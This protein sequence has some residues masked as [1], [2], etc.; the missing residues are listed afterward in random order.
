MGVNV[1]DSL[2]GITLG[3]L[4]ASKAVTLDRN[5]R[6]KGSLVHDT[7]DHFK[8]ET[9]ADG[10]TVRINSRSYTQAS[11]GSIGYQSKPSQTVTTT[12]EVIGAELSP[13]L[14]SGIGAASLTG[15]VATPILKGSVGGDITARFVAYKGELTD[16]NAG[17]RTIAYAAILDAWHQLAGTHTFTAGVHVINARTAGGGTPWTSFLR[18][19]ASGDGGLNV[20]ANGMFKDPEGDTEAGFLKVQVGTTVYEIP[21]YASS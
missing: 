15:H 20:S 12:G 16:E 17:T 7:S 1:T 19:E 21:I 8:I 14:Q 18:A 6:L 4:A 10:K 2:Y 13:R 5:S 3:T 9:S 11:G